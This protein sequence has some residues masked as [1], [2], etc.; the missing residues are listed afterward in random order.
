MKGGKCGKC[1]C[2]GGGFVRGGMRANGRA[3]AA[4]GRR[5]SK[6]LKRDRYG[7]LDRPADETA[8]AHG[9]STRSYA[10]HRINFRSV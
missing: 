8:A 1:R 6:V 7:A 2:G 5:D 9:A 10:A 3:K 4:S